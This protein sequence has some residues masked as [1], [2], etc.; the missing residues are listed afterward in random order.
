MD[1]Y[2][3]TVLFYIQCYTV[4]SVHVQGHVYIQARVSFNPL[5]W[6]SIERVPITVIPSDAH[7]HK[8]LFGG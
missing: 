1:H 5:S 7:L 3:H 2:S 4:L 6:E 8:A